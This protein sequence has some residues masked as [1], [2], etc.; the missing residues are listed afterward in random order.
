MWRPFDHGTRRS[1]IVFRGAVFLAR[2]LEGPR[3]R[4]EWRCG[5]DPFPQA[6][7]VQVHHR[8]D[9]ARHTIAAFLNSRNVGFVSLDCWFCIASLP[10]D[11]IKSMREGV[12]LRCPISIRRQ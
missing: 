12:P 10:R 8:T 1:C 3:A 7:R 6:L 4:C 5:I 2:R 9:P 11:C